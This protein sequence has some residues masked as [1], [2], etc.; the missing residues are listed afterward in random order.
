MYTIVPLNDAVNQNPE[1]LALDK[2]DAD[3]HQ[4][5]WVIQ[6]K[7]QR[8]FVGFEHISYHEYIGLYKKSNDDN[9]C[10]YCLTL[11]SKSEKLCKKAIQGG[12]YNWVRV[13]K[14]GKRLEVDRK[15]PFKKY[16]DL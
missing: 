3:H 1:Q 9:G 12:S 8:L 14:R 13:N 7:S 2:I 5:G 10:F 6:G 16:N 11:A 15:D 4:C